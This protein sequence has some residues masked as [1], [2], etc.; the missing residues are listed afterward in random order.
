[1]RTLS[2]GW[3]IV[4]LLVACATEAGRESTA[5]AG[6]Q[7]PARP[8]ILMVYSD[9]HAT[10]AIGAYGADHAPTPN[11]DRLAAE[12]V[13]FENAFCTN[14][15]CA[16]ARAVVLT[17]QHSHVNGVRDNGDVFDG[18][19]A[20]FPKLLQASGYRTALFGKWHLKDDPIGFDT[21]EILP[22]QGDYYSP[23]FVSPSG[24]R[25]RTGYVTDIVTDLA[26]EWLQEGR[27]D[28][29][30]FLLMVQHKAPHRSWM[31]GPAHVDLFEGETIPEPAT[32]FDDYEG[33]GSAAREQEMT[34][35]EH[36]HPA[37]DLKVPRTDGQEPDGMDRWAASLLGRMTVE[38]RQ[39]WEAAFAPRNDAFRAAGLQDEALVSWKYQ[40]YIKNYLRCIASID[41]NVGRLTDWLDENGLADNTIV[42]YSS[43]QGFFLGEHG[44]YDK[45]FMYEPAL[46]LP[47]IVRWPSGFA[48]GRRVPE[49]VQNLDLAPTFLE[50]ADAYVPRDVE[51]A[52]QGRS[53]LPLLGGDAPNDWR[54]SIYYEYF[55]EGIHAVQPHYGVRTERY[56]LMHFHKLDEWE[57]YDLERDM[58]EMH[59][60]ADDPAYAGVRS[61]LERELQGL[62]QDL[63]VPARSDEAAGDC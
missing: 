34:I 26:I 17:G 9:D 60:V 8:N 33:R 43:D 61:E 16:P 41:D 19:R 15:I 22:G 40:R 54:R 20:T 13:V 4:S 2:V 38:Q 50:A 21:W 53:L 63:D 7:V 36:M 59:S 18:S 56:K 24:K 44:W 37:Y 29:R 35:A 57:L 55:E 27:D 10:A 12:G 51:A 39:T 11:I 42:V 3:A 25:E 58:H 28:E 46:R 32:L 31:P 5:G 30:P 45:R 1:M 49:L 14:A 6:R 52:I 62:R 23:D 48:G 47:L